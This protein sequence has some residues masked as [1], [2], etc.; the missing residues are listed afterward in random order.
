MNGKSKCRIL[1][2]I[3]RQIAQSNRIPYVTSECNYQGACAGTCPKCEAELRYLEQALRKRRQAGKSVVLAG[4]AMALTV[5]MSGCRNGENPEPSMP[6]GSVP[7]PTVPATEQSELIGE[8]PVTTYELLMGEP[9][10]IMGDVAYVES[11]P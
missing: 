6:G 7:Q 5:S 2:D 3:R 10:E 1:K 8:V 9:I 4:V 11:E